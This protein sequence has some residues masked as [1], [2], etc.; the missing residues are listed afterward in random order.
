MLQWYDAKGQAS[1]PSDSEGD[2]I[3]LPTKK[4]TLTVS[5]S[6]I[7]VTCTPIIKRA[8]QYVQQS[9]DVFIDATSSFD[10]RD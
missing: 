6:M 9:R 4:I 1:E 10:C 8:H 5:T 7:L 2:E 3:R